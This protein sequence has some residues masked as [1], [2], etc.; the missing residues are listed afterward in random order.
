MPRS[1]LY[2]FR[3]RLRSGDVINLIVEPSRRIHL[4]SAHVRGTGEVPGKLRNLR[5]LIRNCIVEC[6]EQLDLERVVTFK[7]RCGRFLHE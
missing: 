2:I 7:L 6:I 4:S 5:S 3:I 1:N